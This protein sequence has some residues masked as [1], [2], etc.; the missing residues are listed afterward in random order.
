MITE[1]LVPSKSTEE[2]VLEVKRAAVAEMQRAVAVAV[3]ESRANE[4]LRVH[5]LLD[6]PLSQRNHGSLRQGPFLRVHGNS[7][8]VETNA[9]NVTTPTTTPSSAASTTEDEK[10]VHLTSVTGSVSAKLLIFFNKI[11]NIKACLYRYLHFLGHT[12]PVFLRCP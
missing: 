3:A 12:V 11:L 9:R 2:A 4:R 6:L 10:D 7:N 1:Y 8:T 5:R